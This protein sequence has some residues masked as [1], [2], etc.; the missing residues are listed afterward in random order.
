MIMGEAS[1]PE[2]TGLLYLSVAYRVRRVLD[3]HMMASGLSL[4]RSKVLGVL[5]QN[6]S[7]RQAAL[8]QK[9]GMAQ[10]SV[11]QAV[12]SL[13]RD[14]LVGRTADPADGRAKL[15]SLTAQ[16][17]AVLAASAD[18]GEHVLRQIFGSLDREQ[19]ASLEELV[20]VIDGAANG[21]ELRTS[22]QEF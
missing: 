1:T 14:G 18:T 15:V 9:L 12:E 4:A 6:G 5:A 7:L 16:G 10:R 8:A 11:T 3:Q 17:S 2:Q 21:A 19:L 22:G 20:K 13:A